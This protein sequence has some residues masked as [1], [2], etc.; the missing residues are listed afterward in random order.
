MIYTILAQTSR[1]L[2][3]NFGTPNVD[4]VLK[5]VYRI[6]FL[7]VCPFL[8]LPDALR[9]K[10]FNFS[11]LSHPCFVNDPRKRLKNLSRRWRVGRSSWKRS[12]T[13]SVFSYINVGTNISIVP[14]V[15][16]IHLGEIKYWILLSQEREGLYLS[17]R[18]TRRH[19][20]L[21]TLHWWCI[22]P[23]NHEVCILSFYATFCTQ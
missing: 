21:D 4:L 3:G 1:K 11:E 14:G 10:P 8:I 23:A 2:L 6:F 19:W 15:P 17:I 20:K 22:W 16:D 18:K 12:S 7:H 13:A 9:T 5:L